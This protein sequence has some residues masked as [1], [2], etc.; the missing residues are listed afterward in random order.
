MHF[1]HFNRSCLF[2]P[3]SMMS[4]LQT[5]LRVIGVGNII[6]PNNGVIVVSHHHRRRLMF[7]MIFDAGLRLVLWRNSPVVGVAIKSFWFQKSQPRSYFATCSY[8]KRHDRCAAKFPPLKICNEFGGCIRH[9]N[10]RSD[11]A[12]LDRT[13]LKVIVL[14]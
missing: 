5:F 4:F 13:I 12:L 10:Y 11:M 14:Q 6:A 9:A 3:Q 8:R 7:L 1:V 2:S